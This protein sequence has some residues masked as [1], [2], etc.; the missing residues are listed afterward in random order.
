MSRWHLLSVAEGEIGVRE[1]SRN[2]GKEIEKYWKATDYPEGMENRE[3]WC[4]AFVS[5]CVQRANSEVVLP[6]GRAAVHAWVVWGHATSRIVA[7]ANALPGDVVC[8]VFS[9]IGIVKCA[10]SR[11]MIWSVDGNTN[12]N[13]SR[14]GDCVSLKKRSLDSVLCVIRL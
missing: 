8:F 4:A 3:P 14:E 12:R 6:R 2:S 9:H 7:A 5:W 1:E 13:G 11:G 10:P